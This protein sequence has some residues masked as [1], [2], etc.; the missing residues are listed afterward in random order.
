VRPLVAQIA[1]SVAP[2]RQRFP[3]E[4]WVKLLDTANGRRC[5]TASDGPGNRGSATGRY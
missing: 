5:V 3:R 2:R 1:R 4:S